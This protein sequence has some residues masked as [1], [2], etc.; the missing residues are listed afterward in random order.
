[1]SKRALWSLGLGAASAV[2]AFFV[3]PAAAHAADVFKLGAGVMGAAGANWI[4]KPSNASVSYPGFAGFTAGG[5]LML[6]ARALGLVGVEVDLY[7]ADNHGEG[8]LTAGST[9][10]TLK[11]GQPAL[12][13]PIL[14]KVVVPTGI[15]RP[16]VV[17]GPELVFPG[18]SDFSASPSGAF[19]TRATV[20]ADS[21]TMWTGGLGLE[22]KLPLPMIDLRIPVGLRFG[23]N[24]AL[25]DTLDKRAEIRGTSGNVV[26]DI[27]YKSEWEY[28]AQLTLGA[29]VHF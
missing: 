7:R 11:I 18:T 2:F 14:L 4:S 19:A 26:T 21:Y 5:G 16:F 29:A 20:S 13:V 24:P 15:V 6:E 27:H 10:A 25:G 22:I 28:Q 9:T 12:H 3:A 23:L 17:F 1:M 8:D